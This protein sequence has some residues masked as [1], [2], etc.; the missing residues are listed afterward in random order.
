LHD[1]QAELAI[2][3]TA[4]V[5][6]RLMRSLVK[7][8]EQA[9][10]PSAALLRAARL[11]PEDLEAPDGRMP[12][13]ELYRPFE[14]AI[15]LTR[16]PAFGLHWA[17]TM[18]QNG[19][20]LMAQLVAH[21]AHLRQGFE[22]LARFSALL[23]DVMGYELLESEECITVRAK[24]FAGT[25]PVMER[26]CGEMMVLGFYRLIRSFAID[27]RRVRVSFAYS[28]PSYQSEYT[29][30]FEG[31]VLFDQPITGV[32][33]DRALFETPS[34]NR[35]LEVHQALQAV[36]QR[37]LLPTA[38]TGPY[39]VRVREFLVQQGG[40]HRTDMET[41]AYAVGLSVRSL[42][43]RLTSEGKT[44]NELANDAFVILAQRLLWDQGRTIQEAAY[45]LGF[46]K[47]STF[48]RAFKRCTGDT[49]SAFRASQLTPK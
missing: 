14:L 41:A 7:T 10:G 2:L 8:V 25:P 47:A 22:S 45:T 23:G 4:T 13:L 29:R 43:R 11:T 48:H 21:S 42:R 49:P 34:P 3:R 24:R 5:S 40:A 38:P 27:P 15:E 12:C 31:P 44:Y 30:L 35:D 37:R 26:L 28:A 1:L 18:D 32:V 6:L 19:L 16:D 39:A 36:A 17:E 9:G 46:S 20:G 33:F